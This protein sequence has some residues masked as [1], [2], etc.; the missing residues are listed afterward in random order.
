[1]EYIIIL[2]QWTANSL[3]SH[4]L[5]W[6]KCLQLTIRKLLQEFLIF[7]ILSSSRILDNMQNLT[8]TRI[9]S[10]RKSMFL[11]PEIQAIVPQL[12]DPL[13]KQEARIYDS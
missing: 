5:W 9:L 10:K 11:L 13:I 8:F 12:P 1:M 4:S 6:S 7:I 2:K 3:G